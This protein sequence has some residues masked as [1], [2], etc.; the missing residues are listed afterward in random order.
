MLLNYFVNVMTLKCY[1]A[2]SAVVLMYVPSINQSVTATV[3]VE[4]AVELKC[5]FHRDTKSSC[6]AGPLALCVFMFSATEEIGWLK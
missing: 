6:A 3:L 4:T 2:M 5:L 1:Y